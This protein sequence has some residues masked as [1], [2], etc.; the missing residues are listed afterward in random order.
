MELRNGFF[1]TLLGLRPAR[2][3]GEYWY[4]FENYHGAPAPDFSAGVVPAQSP[5]T[6][7]STAAPSQRR[8]PSQIPSR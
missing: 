2:S 5:V 7:G 6:T 8:N 3:V 1:N 4:V